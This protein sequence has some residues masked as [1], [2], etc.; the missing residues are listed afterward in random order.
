VAEGLLGHKAEAPG[1]LVRS[2]PLAAV[3]AVAAH[4]LREGHNLG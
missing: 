4:W 3:E 1:L 2:G